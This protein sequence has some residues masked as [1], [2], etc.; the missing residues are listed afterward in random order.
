MT[1]NQL[2]ILVIGA[3]LMV[4][5]IMYIIHLGKQD[6]PGKREKTVSY[7]LVVFGLIIAILPFLSGMSSPEELLP[8]S[9]PQESQLMGEEV[10]G[11]DMPRSTENYSKAT[12]WYEKAIALWNVEVGSF[13]ST[14]KV[15]EYLNKSIENYETAEALTARGQLKVQIADM[16]SAMEDY[17]RAV[18]LKDDYPNSFFNRGALYYIFGD[19][20]KACADWKRAADLGL[21]Q[22]MTTYGSMCG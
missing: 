7:A 18:E 10:F 2:L 22:A 8:R 16:M 5:G 11:A 21:E 20:E 9:K 19:R 3:F 17:E 12:E 1:S 6:N 4:T 13:D 14:N 15:M